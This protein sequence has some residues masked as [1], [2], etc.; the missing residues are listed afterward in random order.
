MSNITWGNYLPPTDGSN[1]P[2]NQP[3]DHT[4]EMPAV[5]T[6]DYPAAPAPPEQTGE[7]I[8]AVGTQVLPEKPIKTPFGELW[9]TSLA[10]VRAQPKTF[11]WIPTCIA[12]IPMLCAGIVGAG[13]VKSLGAIFGGGSTH[14][15]INN[16]DWDTSEFDSWS[17]TNMDSSSWSDSDMS[18]DMSTDIDADMT[19]NMSDMKAGNMGAD[20]I[21]APGDIASTV[22]QAPEFEP[23]SAVN[24]IDAVDSSSIND[25]ASSGGGGLMSVAIILAAILLPL[26][27]VLS[28]ALLAMTVQ[29]AR[30]ERPTWKKSITRKQT[31]AAIG[32]MFAVQVLLMAA[33]GILMFLVGMIFGDHATIPV[34]IISILTFIAMILAMLMP[35]AAADMSTE[36]MT[37]MPYMQRLTFSMGV[38][39][40]NI[41]SIIGISVIFT[42]ALPLMIIP[43]LNGIIMSMPMMMYARMYTNSVPVR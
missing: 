10:D 39:A 4:L 35:T 12:Y 26:F 21:D 41:L 32:T 13:V 9:K 16:N 36:T 1:N 42:L 19:T 2:N 38:V 15:T 29:R 43:G 33:G 20:S 6:T 37:A 23:M 31:W 5:D 18:T 25:A 34:A 24:M 7:L 3:I 30:G 14:I 8:P 11:I 28:Y 40:K 22:H 27:S 17:D